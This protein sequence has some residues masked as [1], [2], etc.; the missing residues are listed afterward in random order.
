[1]MHPNALLPEAEAFGGFKK[2][3]NKVE[4]HIDS[5]SL[6]KDQVVNKSIS[7]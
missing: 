7:A 5:F 3:D 4:T 2:L 1:M 6:A